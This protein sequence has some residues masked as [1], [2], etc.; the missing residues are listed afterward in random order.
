MPAEIITIQGERR[1]V[2]HSPSW[3]AAHV[4]NQTRMNVANEAS[5]RNGASMVGPAPN[6][7]CEFKLTTGGTFYVNPTQ[8]ASVD[9]SV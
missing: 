3:V 5:F 6:T 1:I 9:D 2:D 8:V 4:A 7:M